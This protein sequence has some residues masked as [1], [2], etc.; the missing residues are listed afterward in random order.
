MSHKM[1]VKIQMNGSFVIMML[2]FYEYVHYY[3]GGV[4]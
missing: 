4:R 1:V 3:G 2:L